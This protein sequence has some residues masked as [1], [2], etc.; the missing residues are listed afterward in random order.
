VRLP[1]GTRIERAM[2]LGG[3]R[4]DLDLIEHPGTIVS[5]LRGQK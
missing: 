2:G 3:G 1:I 4:S 5:K